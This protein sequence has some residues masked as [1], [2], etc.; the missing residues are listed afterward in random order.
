MA[1]TPITRS[2]SRH[3]L[4]DLSPNRICRTCNLPRRHF[5]SSLPSPPRPPASGIAPLASRRLLSVTGPDAA[6][7][8]QGIITANV[9]SNKGEP[10][11]DP[12][13]TAFLNA[14]GRVLHDVF[15]YPVRGAPGEDADGFLVEVDAAQTNALM[16][17]IKRYK[18]RA[19]VAFRAIDPDEISVW[20]AWNDETAASSSTTLDIPADPSR[21]VFRD[22]RAPGLGHRIIQLA[23]QKPPEV[24]VERATEDAYTIRRYL[25]GVPEGQDEILREQALPLESNMEHMGGIDFHKGCYVGQELTIRTKHRGVVRKRILPCAIYDRAKAPPSS[26]VYDLD[27]DS[28]EGG[29]EAVTA[30]MIPAETSIGRAGKRGRSAGKWLRGVGNIGLGLCRLEIMT[31]VVLPGEQAAA[32]FRDGDEF[33]LEWGEEDNKSGVKVKAFVPE[34]LRRSLDGQQ[35]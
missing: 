35:R 20:H 29:P 25:H 24:D 31:D 22:P 32:T 27:L 1:S 9:V 19:K 10:R 14:T 13:Y 23:G 16:K 33:E 17:Y 2:L 34:W 21:I 28:S 6:K 11:T 30:D 12:F 5:S 18:L 7:F 4:H 3:P 15:I 26:L 8:L